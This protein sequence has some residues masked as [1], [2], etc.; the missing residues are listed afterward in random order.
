MRSADRIGHVFGTQKH[1]SWVPSSVLGGGFTA[2]TVPVKLPAN[3]R[4]HTARVVE[5][6]AEA[7]G[8]CSHQA[9]HLPVWTPTESPGGGISEPQPPN[10]RGSSSAR[11]RAAA[12]KTRRTC[13]ASGRPTGGAREQLITLLRPSAYIS[14]RAPETHPE[15]TLRPRCRLRCSQGPG[16]ALLLSE[17]SGPPH[18]APTVVTV[19]IFCR[20]LVCV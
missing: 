12:R 3:C 15:V 19:L 2:L 17:V 20:S 1:S 11:D 7:M 5:T 10:H 9:T 13:S 8:S 14:Q 6:N 18:P 4:N 16:A